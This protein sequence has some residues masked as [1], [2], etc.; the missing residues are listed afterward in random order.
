[1]EL[2]EVEVNDEEVDW[3]TERDPT[4]SGGG[5]EPH[6]QTLAIIEF[7]SWEEATSKAGN[8]PSTT[9][10]ID[11][12]TKNDNGR[13]FVRCRS[14]ARDFKPRR[15]GSD[16]RLVRGDATAGRKESTVCVAREETR[17]GP[18][19]S[20]PHVHRREASAPQ[21]EMR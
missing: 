5:D 4:R 3:R 15:E 16:G 2:A 11:R 9:K 6:G 18:R 14:V 8:A 12:M 19:R 21:R 13:E 10:R 1:M 20:E 7:G 17:T